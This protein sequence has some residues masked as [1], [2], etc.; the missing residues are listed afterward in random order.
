MQINSVWAH[1]LL[2]KINKGNHDRIIL[3]FSQEVAT[4]T[5]DTVMTATKYA[6]IAVLLLVGVSVLYAGMGI[7]IVTHV[8]GT[9]SY[10]VIVGITFILFALMTARFRK[11]RPSGDTRA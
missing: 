6:L 10:G 1:Q 9:A 4:W 11:D 2:M 7:D 3:R 8:P 5:N